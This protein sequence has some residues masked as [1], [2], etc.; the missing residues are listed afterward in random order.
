[1]NKRELAT[2]ISDLERVLSQYRS[3]VLGSHYRATIPTGK[4]IRL[5]ISLQGQGRINY[6][7]LNS[8]AH[9]EFGIPSFELKSSYLPLFTEWG[10]ISVYDDYIEE[11]IDSREKILVRAADFWEEQDPHPVEKLSLNIY[12]MAAKRPQTQDVTQTI[13]DQYVEADCD[14]CLS[15]LRGSGLVD[16]FSFKD[17][18]WYYSPEV[19]GENYKDVISFL[20]SQTEDSRNNIND[21]IS[22][23]TEDQGVPY[24]I[25]AGRYGAQLPNQVA[26]VGILYGYPLAIGSDENTFYFTPDLRSRFEREGRGDKFEIIKPGVAHFQYAHKLAALQTGRLR[27]NPSVLLDKLI[28]KGFAGDAT[29]IGTDYELLVKKGLIKIEPTYANRYRFLLPDSREKIADLEAIRDAFDTKQIVPQIDFNTLGLRGKITTQ[30]SLVHR[31]EYFI[32]NKKLA[33]QFVTEVFKL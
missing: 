12:D 28:E 18:S 3:P 9:S 8:I 25:L 22:A 6:A 33:K 13:L 14:S 2:R 17:T 4:A 10:F 31:S 29:A 27:F 24:D 5:L 23:V 19:F 30:D 7:T 16:T 11:E 1:M 21:L 26:G 20:S 32:R 15:H